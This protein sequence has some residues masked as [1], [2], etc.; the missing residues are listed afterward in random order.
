MTKRKSNGED[1]F[2]KD[3]TSGKWKGK[4]EKGIN[5]KSNRKFK[6]C[7]GNSEKEVRLRLKDLM[8]KHN[9]GSSKCIKIG[10]FLKNNFT[11]VR[12]MD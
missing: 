9:A 6:S 3:T 1:C 12:Y 7:T 10:E 4:F 2:Y 11:I 5:V 8:S